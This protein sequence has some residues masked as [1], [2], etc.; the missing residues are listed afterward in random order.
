MREDGKVLF[1]LYPQDWRLEKG[2]RIG[3]LLSGSDD[4]WFMPGVSGTDVTVSGGD[5]S[6]PFLRYDRDNFLKG[7][8]SN[9]MA[10][11]KP[12]PVNAQVLK[13][14]TVKAKLPPKLKG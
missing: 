13:T 4:S 3:L 5:V 9:A 10:T 14:R 8:P 11:R 12:F 7:G 6:I 2:H 1:D